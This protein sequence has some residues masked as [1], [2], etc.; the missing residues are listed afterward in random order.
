MTLSFRNHASLL[1]IFFLTLVLF[2]YCYYNTSIRQITQTK[3]H[4][5]DCVPKPTCIMITLFLII[6]ISHYYLDCSLHHLNHIISLQFGCYPILIWLLSD[7]IH[8][9]CECDLPCAARSTCGL[10]QDPQAPAGHRLVWPL[11]S[12][13]SPAESGE[14]RRHGL[15]SARPRPACSG[16]NKAT[17]VIR[18]SVSVFFITRSGGISLK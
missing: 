13:A 4:K 6:T 18:Y 2:T 3:R 11:L 15:T 1:C 12:A 5:M 16:C 10:C 14:H 9:D 17:G 8:G 7:I